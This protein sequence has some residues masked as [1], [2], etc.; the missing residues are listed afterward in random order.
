MK[1]RNYEMTVVRTRRTLVPLE[2]AAGR[3]GLHPDIVRRFM[4]FGLFE[5]AEV[6]GARI[7]LDSAALRRI[8]VIQHLRNDLGVNLAGIGVVLELLDRIEA[9][10]RGGG[11]GYQ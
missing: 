5:P 4:E 6:T 1:T 8:G 2:D 3:L 9:L 10:Q 7:M 11:R